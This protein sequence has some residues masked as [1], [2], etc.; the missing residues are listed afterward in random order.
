MSLEEEATMT[1]HE[2]EELLS[3]KGWTKTRLAAE[4]HVTEHAV[5]AWLKR[6]RHPSGPADVLM[7][8]WLD[9]ARKRKPLG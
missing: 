7:R 8:Q 6:G 4:L 5:T 1:A 9:E 3:R 2:I